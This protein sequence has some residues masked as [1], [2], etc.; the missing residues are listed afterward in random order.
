MIKNRLST[1]LAERGLKITKV[2]NETGISRNTITSIS[3]NDSE[4]IRLETIN[5]LCT[6]LGVTPCEFFDFV[7]IE[8]EFTVIINNISYNVFHPILEPE[9]DSNL[10][11]ISDLDIDI[12]MKVKES[13][14]INNFVL[15]CTLIE[16]LEFPLYSSPQYTRG[17]AIRVDVLGTSREKEVLREIYSKINSSFQ[18]DIES[19]LTLSIEVAMQKWIKEDHHNYLKGINHKRIGVFGDIFNDA[20]DEYFF[21]RG[22]KLDILNQL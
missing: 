9:S 17:I 5:T 2:S 8:V 14:I 10:F 21:V 4:M 13:T 1:L 6:Y 11:D 22:L 7:P 12:F 18:T 19:D 16:P 3:Q 20:V 15:K